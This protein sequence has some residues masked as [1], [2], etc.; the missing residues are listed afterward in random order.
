MN[1]GGCASCFW[2]SMKVS[3]RVRVPPAFIELRNMLAGPLMFSLSNEARKTQKTCTIKD[4]DTIGP[5]A[6]I[7]D[8]AVEGFPN[9]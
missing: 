1:I 5:H 6:D 4:Q 7:G 8:F 3:E 9:P 2:G